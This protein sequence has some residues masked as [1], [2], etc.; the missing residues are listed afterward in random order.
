MWGRN[1]RKRIARVTR[2]KA[3]QSILGRRILTQS[4]ECLACRAFDS[5]YA[6]DKRFEE[7][8]RYVSEQIIQNAASASKHRHVSMTT[9]GA[10]AFIT[11]T[12][13]VEVLAPERIR[14]TSCASKCAGAKPVLLRV[15]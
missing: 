3:Q 2:A 15:C 11:F 4:P 10:S 5:L 1:D 8:T 7:F 13:S 14:I 6:K 12:V 9:D